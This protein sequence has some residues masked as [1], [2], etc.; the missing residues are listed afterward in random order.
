MLPKNTATDSATAAVVAPRR[1]KTLAGEHATANSSAAAV[2]FATSGLQFAATPREVES[3]RTTQFVA[4]V[5]PTIQ[6]AYTCSAGAKGQ[7]QTVSIHRTCQGA[8][9]G[10][11]HR[12]D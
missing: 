10:Q 9:Y 12:G 4:K 11:A 1:A 5:V 8:P 3:A 6:E 7:C 2:P